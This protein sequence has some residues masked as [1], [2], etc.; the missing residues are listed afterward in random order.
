MQLSYQSPQV[1]YVTKTPPR[2]D[3]KLII[4]WQND[5]FKHINFKYQLFYMALAKLLHV[6]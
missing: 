3:A 6:N 2:L 4:L 1:C 5:E